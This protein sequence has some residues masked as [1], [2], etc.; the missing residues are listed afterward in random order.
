MGAR[1]KFRNPRRPLEKHDCEANA[2]QLLY[3]NKNKHKQF[4]AESL[5]ND[6]NLKKSKISKLKLYQ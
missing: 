3:K 5:E 6:R 1:S 2:G 4:A